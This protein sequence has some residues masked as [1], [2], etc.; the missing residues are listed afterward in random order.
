MQT[1]FLLGYNKREGSRL[2]A[3]KAPHRLLM[4]YP[5]VLNPPTPPH[6]SHNTS[7][8]VH[9]QKIWRQF[10]LPPIPLMEI[11]D[12]EYGRSSRKY[13]PPPLCVFLVS[14]HLFR[15]NSLSISPGKVWTLILS[16][17]CNISPHLLQH[18]P[19]NKPRKK[20]FFYNKKNF[21]FSWVRRK[22]KSVTFTRK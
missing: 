13:P 12:K 21:F 4:A 2:T 17:L 15:K 9:D 20:I 5:S 18:N 22:C 8:P 7:C 6:F 10:R 11:T 1:N 3:R 14:N 19:F 16:W